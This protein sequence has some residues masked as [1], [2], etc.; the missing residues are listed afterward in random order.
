MMAYNVKTQNAWWFRLIPWRVKSSCMRLGYRFFGESNSS[1]TLTNLGRV[2]LPVEM[3]PYVENVQAFLTPRT[4][5]PYGCAVL[6]YGDKV[7]INM[8]R[9]TP[10][11]ELDTVFFQKL[12]A[13][14][15]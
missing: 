6:T 4:G 2:Q 12:Q 7:N 1:L 15:E 8:S 11:P 13:V 10:E 5:S 9:F 3:Q 14:M